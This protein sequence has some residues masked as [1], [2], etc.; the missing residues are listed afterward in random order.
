MA[1]STSTDN[2]KLLRTLAPYAALL[3]VIESE[4]KTFSDRSDTIIARHSSYGALD[5]VEQVESTVDS[6]RTAFRQ[7]ATTI[8]D[9]CRRI[10][11]DQ[12]LVVSKLPVAPTAG[13]TEVITALQTAMGAIDYGKDIAVSGLDES[14][15]FDGGTSDV[16][17]ASFPLATTQAGRI[18]MRLFLTTYLD[19]V[20]QP[21]NAV[22]AMGLNAG[23]LTQSTKDSETF[24]VS[25][26]ADSETG[27]R[28][29]GQELFSIY[30]KNTGQ[31]YDGGYPS[32]G[33]LTNIGTAHQAGEAFTPSNALLPTFTVAD[34]PDGWTVE[35]GTPGTQFS[36]DD[37]NTFRGASTIAIGS[38]V[39][40][41]LTK[42]IPSA[43]IVRG[44]LYLLYWWERAG[45][46]GAPVPVISDPAVSGSE[47]LGTAIETKVYAA[48]GTDAQQ[49]YS[50]GTKWRLRYSV[51]RARA[52]Q[53]ATSYTLRLASAGTNA[54]CSITSIGL[55]PIS[56]YGGL[57]Y[58]LIPGDSDPLLGSR[59]EIG[60]TSTVGASGAPDAVQY[61]GGINDFFVKALG[62]QPYYTQTFTNPDDN[63]VYDQI[64]YPDS[65][66]GEDLDTVP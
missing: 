49:A 63:P 37:T 57:G 59:W 21:S 23:R 1:W 38:N 56:Y 34:T 33:S 51:Y 22:L 18:N 3:R 66:S 28:P 50:T 35:S 31:L 36:E 9:Q 45:A 2:P 42:S 6:A 47:G 24:V 39:T 62:V 54:A 60:V 43:S 26:A 61:Y 27:G 5:S 15:A 44:G 30:S 13:F 52:T 41:E 7:V 12:D 17:I 20:S 10:I 53:P 11:L 19:G 65:D 25:L 48:T 32:S 46:Q 16:N 40:F 14:L 64:F 4:A 29:A 55:A 8:I 58:L